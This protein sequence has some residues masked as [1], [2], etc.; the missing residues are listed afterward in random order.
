MSPTSDP[1]FGVA[2]Y[3]SLS[4]I[5][6][7]AWGT[8]LAVVGAAGTA[9][10]LWAREPDVVDGVNAAHENKRFL[11]GV[12]LP[13]GLRATA[14][15]AVAAKA[16]A[17][18][19]VPPAQFLR[20]TASQ[21]R[22]LIAPGTPVVLCAKGIEDKTGALLTEVLKETLPE[23]SPAMLSGPSFARDVARGLPTA[24]TVAAACGIAERLQSTLGRA[25]GFRPYITDDLV[26]VA[27]GGAA[28]NVYAIACGMV[29]GA[30]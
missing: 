16:E 22:G 21:L 13:P 26:G 5:G 10:L 15:L 7:G 27:L 18:L 23:A 25:R 2:P 9:T 19:L 28:K 11:S 17:V 20:A 12:A 30:G 4:V 14:D 1:S 29:M 8:A 24:V 3:S 6:G